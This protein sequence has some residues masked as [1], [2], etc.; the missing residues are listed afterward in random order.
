MALCAAI[1][2]GHIGGMLNFVDCTEDTH[3]RPILDI[4][5]HAILHSTALYD[6]HPRPTESMRS[7]FETKR[8]GSYPVIGAVEDGVLVGFATYGIFRE[9]PAY[10][11]SVEHSVYV[12]H[13]HRG[14]G[15]GLEL[16]RR[17]IRCAETQGY[18]LMV[19]GIDAENVASIR[20]HEKLGFTHAGTIREA[21]FKFGKW[22]NLAFYQLVLATPA[23][24]VD[25]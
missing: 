8:R 23:N 5:N 7:W 11:Y 10:K 3:S 19:G 21:G 14:R 16:L 6:Y 20:L 17:L 4:F 12:H 25:G 2:V 15:V 24:P 22:L 13:E 1:A 18:H 9:R